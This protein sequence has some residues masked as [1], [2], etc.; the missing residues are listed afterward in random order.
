MS[1]RLRAALV[2][3]AL[4]PL[5]VLS[6]AF[7]AVTDVVEVVRELSWGPPD[8]AGLDRLALALERGGPGAVP[9]PKEVAA[10]IGDVELLVV[11]YCPVPAALLDAAPHLAVLA[12][13]RAGTENLDVEE[14]HARGAEVV[15]VV[16]RT[17]EAVSDF[18]IGLL[19]A[20]ARNIARAHARIVAGRWDKAFPNS[21]FTPEMEGQTVGLVGFGE[22]GRAVCRKLAGFNVR[23]LAHDPFVD[24]AAV[25]AAGAEPAA[26]DELLAESDFV[27]LHARPTPGR[28]PMIGARELALMKPTAILVN[29][30]RS[31]LI[32]AEALYDALREHRLAGAAMDVHDQEPLPPGHP[33]LTLDNV[34]LTPHLASSTL[35]CTEKSPE[36]LAADL[37]GFLRG[38]KLRNPV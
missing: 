22:I 15:H 6:R 21:A 14:A 19:L 7:E 23:V 1:R 13:C 35:R 34:T 29:T 16:G 37:A 32:D 11:H 26:L 12:T 9:F 8:E 36:M 18:T 28:P 27:S 3:D 31:A 30:A 25:R 33:L 4:L 5:P 38:G 24:E 20:E 17:T 10:A 2:G